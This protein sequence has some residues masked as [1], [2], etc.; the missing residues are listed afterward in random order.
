MASYAVQCPCCGR[1]YDSSKYLGCPKCAPGLNE[2]GDLF[3]SDDIRERS[4]EAMRDVGSFNSILAGR[5]PKEK[6]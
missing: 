1:T 5:K 6:R 3:G 2:S 4:K